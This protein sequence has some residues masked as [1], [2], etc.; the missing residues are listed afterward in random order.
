MKREF[1]VFHYKVVHTKEIHG[2]KTGGATRGV[3]GFDV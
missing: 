2:E 1:H 3:V